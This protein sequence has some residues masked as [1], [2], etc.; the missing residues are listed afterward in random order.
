MIYG[1]EWPPKPRAIERY[2]THN[3]DGF[4]FGS[5]CSLDYDIILE[6]VEI[7]KTPKRDVVFQSVAGRDGDLIIDNHRWYNTEATYF[8]AIPTGFGEK[9]DYFI[10]ALLTQTGYQRLDDSIYPGVYRMGIVIDS[11]SPDVMRRNK[12]GRF[13][14]TFLCKPQRYLKSGDYKT[15]YETPIT[16]H[17]SYGGTAK[18]LITVHG[19]GPGTLT[20]GGVIVE[21]KALADQI[22]LDCEIGNAYR[23]VGNA[24]PENKNLDIYAPVFPELPPGENPIS[25]TGGITSIDI[26]P[27]WWML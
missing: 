14:V 16:L 27:R 26:I 15:T 22:T 7:R 25:W 24:A 2:H 1:I 4:W 19:T 8:C 18:P 20:V 13:D 5:I 10:N 21:I 9:F 11:I 6:G 17:N 3:N 12:T 23:Q